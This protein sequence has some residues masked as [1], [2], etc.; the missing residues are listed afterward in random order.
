MHSGYRDYLVSS[1][2]TPGWQKIAQKLPQCRR[3]VLD[4]AFGSAI[5][6]TSNREACECLQRVRQLVCQETSPEKLTSGRDSL[7]APA[8]LHFL[9]A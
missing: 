4:A 6:E 5:L 2:Q 9:S 8:L 7:R 1:V 3:G